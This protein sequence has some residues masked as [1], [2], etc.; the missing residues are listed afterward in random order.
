[1]TQS[2]A[3]SGVIKVGSSFYHGL[4][5]VTVLKVLEGFMYELSDGWKVCRR[6][7]LSQDLR[8]TAPRQR[9]S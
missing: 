5:K 4:H 6:L 1:M 8:L 3:F 2:D 9:L 7:H